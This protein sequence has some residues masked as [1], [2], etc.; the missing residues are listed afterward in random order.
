MTS[1][2][3]TGR[4]EGSAAPVRRPDHTQGRL[5]PEKERGD[6]A[7][8]SSLQAQVA[9]KRVEVAGI[10]PASFSA[11]PWLLRVQYVVSFYSASALVRTHR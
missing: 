7:S 5:H 11:T 6:P 10:E 8:K 1:G 4:R 2:P 9:S 3:S